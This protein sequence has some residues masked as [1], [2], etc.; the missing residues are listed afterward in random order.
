[1]N[2]EEAL[3][4]WGRRKL[5]KRYPKHDKDKTVSVKIELDQGYAC[6]GGRDPDCYCSYAESPSAYILISSGRNEVKI[7]VEELDIAGLA[8]E[9][10]DIVNEGIDND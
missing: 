3:E 4:E 6:C 1:M 9:L 7:F 2:Y 5:V 8:M 10:T